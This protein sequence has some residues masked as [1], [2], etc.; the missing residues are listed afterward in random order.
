MLPILQIGP[1]AVQTPGLILLAGVW[2]GLSLAERY[3]GQFKANPAHLYNLAFNALIAGI[4]GARLFYAA[5]YPSAFLAAPLS[6]VSLNPGLLDPAGGLAAGLVTALVYG[7]RKGMGLWPTLDALTPALAAFMLALALAN[8]ASGNDFG[9]PTELPWGIELWG[10]RRHPSQI[11]EALAAGLILWVVWPTRQR[12][13]QAAGAMFLKFV[14]LTSGA[15]LFLEAFRGDSNIL[16]AGIRAEQVAAWV[17]LAVAL[18]LW[19]NHKSRIA[20][21]SLRE[22]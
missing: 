8:L 9:A 6:L 2:I 19:G 10:A 20:R 12:G 13:E 4:L 18:W 15:R 3:A 1:L 14:A 17:V 22:R 16:A 5:R 7:R 11:Y 21:R